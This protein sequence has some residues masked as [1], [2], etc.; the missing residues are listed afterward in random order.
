[1]AYGLLGDSPEFRIFDQ[2]PMAPQPTQFSRPGMENQQRGGSPFLQ[3]LADNQ[4]AL[5]MA[6]AGFLSDEGGRGGGMAGWARGGEIDAKRRKEKQDEEER[7]RKQDAVREWARIRVQSGQMTPGD[8][9]LLEVYGLDAA[10]LFDEHN[11][12]NIETFYDP[13]TGREVKGIYDPNAPGG[14]RPVGGMKADD[15]GGGGLIDQYNLYVDQEQTAGRQPVSFMD[16]RLQL[17]RAG[18]TSID[19]GAGRLGPNQRWIDPNDPSKGAEPIPGSTAEAMPAELAARIGLA[20]DALT[21]LDEVE[22]AASEGKMT[23]AWDYAA[24]QLGR[25]VQGQMRRELQAGAEALT[26]MLTGAGMNMAEVN[27]EVQMYLPSVFDDAP[28]LTSKIQQLKRRLKATVAEA[29]RGRGGPP[30][31]VEPAVIDPGMPTQEELEAMTPEE[32]ALFGQ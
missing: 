15:G 21:K 14:F 23:G 26:R 12:P 13:A 9:K 30:R 1:M 7:R 25:G 31:G 27:R 3:W 16:F 28:T 6:S 2:S 5:A 32:R 18:A 19:L 24:G 29:M 8:A 11:A 17:A 20:N 4:G 22:K 10:K